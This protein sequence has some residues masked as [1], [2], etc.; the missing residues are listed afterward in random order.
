MAGWGKEG[1]SSRRRAEDHAC[2]AR[3]KTLTP[4]IFFKPEAVPEITGDQGRVVWAR[5]QPEHY[6]STTFF[7]YKSV[8][9]HAGVLAPHALGGSSASGYS[10]ENDVWELL[11]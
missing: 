4:V 3:D 9:K 5:V 6:R 11:P 8:L 7:Q 1:R 2:A 10:P